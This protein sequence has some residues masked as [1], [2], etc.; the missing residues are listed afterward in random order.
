MTT[1]FGILTK[2]G[3]AKEANAKA[4]GVPVKIAEMEVGDGGGVLPVPDRE[5]TSLIGSKHRAPINRIFVDPSNPAWLVVEQVIPE[6]FGGWWARELG[7][8]DADGDLIAVS[9][10]PP[11]YKPQMAEGS[12]R[13]QVVRMVLQVSSTS[14]FTLK[15][16]PA[17]VLATRQYVD[18]GLAG[19]LNRDAW[20]NAKDGGI[21]RLAT[22]DE[23]REL[24]HASAVIT[25]QTL[26]QVTA[27]TARRGLIMQSTLTDVL[28]GQDQQTSASP[29]AVHNAVKTMKGYRAFLSSGTFTVPA[30]V[31]MLYVSGC[32]AGGGGGAGA[33]YTANSQYPGGGGGAGQFVIL[34]PYPVTPGEVIPVTIGFGGG[35][36]L[37]QQAGQAGGSGQTGGVSQFGSLRL[38]GGAGGSG[39]SVGGGGQ[40][41]DGFPRGGG[42]ATLF[43]LGTAGTSM[44]IM[45]GSGAPSPF[46]APGQ[47]ASSASFNIIGANAVGH[48]AGGAGGNALTALG[49]GSNGGTGAPGAFF[50]YW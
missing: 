27:T 47:G 44:L 43:N 17:V 20:A 30:G 45:S 21:T 29:Y 6:Q 26:G 38:L 7:L 15:I 22:T 9:N 19:K 24:T 35:G 40:G 42:A 49:T 41:G 32:A 4:L 33:G 23:A 13:T 48:G 31:T 3:E 36:G 14:N 10:C 5:Q 11:T 34:Q 39:G 16:D 8:R 28:T 12:A 25:P 2:I 18:D 1:Y 50:I 46:G 37:G